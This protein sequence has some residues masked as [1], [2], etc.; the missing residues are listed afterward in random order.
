MP[1]GAH[2]SILRSLLVPRFVQVARGL[3]SDFAQTNSTGT[4]TR[5]EEIF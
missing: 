3:S 2:L 4:L 1:L 5:P